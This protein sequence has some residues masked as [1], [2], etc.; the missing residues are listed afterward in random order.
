MLPKET[1]LEQLLFFPEILCPIP[2]YIFC[3]GDLVSLFFPSWVSAAARA[4]CCRCWAGRSLVAVHELLMQRPLL[5]QRRLWVRELQCCGSRAAED[6]L[7]SCGARAPPRVGSSQIRG[8]AC[9][10]RRQIIYPWAAGEAQHWAACACHLLCFCKYASRGNFLQWNCHLRYFYFFFKRFCH[11]E[12][13][14]TGRCFQK[15]MYMFFFVNS[16][17]SI[18]S[19]LDFVGTIEKYLLSKVTDVIKGNF[20]RACVLASF[21]TLWLLTG[22]MR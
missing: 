18:M 7:S 8:H 10:F 12:S 15:S 20:R 19:V 17:R 2:P 13:R 14:W 21:L 22:T 5:L 16:K 1:T 9:V 3:R 6:R 11:W 4:S